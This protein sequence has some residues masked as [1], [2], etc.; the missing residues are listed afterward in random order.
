MSQWILQASSGLTARDVA[1]TYV[2]DNKV[3]MSDGYQVGNV[4]RLDI[5]NSSNGK[6]WNT[7]TYPHP[8]QKYPSTGVH[9]GFMWFI[10]GTVNKTTDG[11]NFTQVTATG[12]VPP[13]LPEAPFVS[14]NGKMHIIGNDKVYSSTDGTSWTVKSAP[15]GFRVFHMACVFDGKVFVS[16]GGYNTPNSPAEGGY[17]DKTSLND[18]WYTSTPEDETSW[19]Q[20][21]APFE[22]RF[23]PAMAVHNNALYLVGGYN[24][25][26][27]TP[28]N[29]GDTWKTTDGIN[30]SKVQ[31]SQSFPD[32]HAP[33]VY[34]WDGSLYLACGNTNTGNSIQNDVWKL[35]ETDMSDP[36]QVT[37]SRPTT[38]TANGFGG[39]TVR[40]RIP[41]SEMN[42]PANTPTFIRLTLDGASTGVGECYVG[43]AGVDHDFASTPTQ[44]TK[45]GQNSFTVAG[46][47]EVTDDIPFVWDGI[48]DII[49][50]TYIT[51]GNL[52]KVSGAGYHYEVA[53]N[54]ANTIGATGFYGSMYNPNITTIVSKI[55]M[56]G[57]GASSG[58]GTPP[59]PVL[60]GY[61]L[62]N[63]LIDSAETNI[64]VNNDTALTDLKDAMREL[65]NILDV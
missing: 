38:S 48:S 15:W 18:V 2:Y 56:D 3:W 24:N 36:I 54:K 60:T 8:F 10:D 34:S 43:H 40:T 31:V 44:V 21:Q 35:E 13:Y 23:W 57:Y 59:D 42:A 58:G 20:Y 37:F 33:S 53:G 62:V 17:T 16:C 41:A 5:L 4:P 22:P 7:V 47:N 50:S 6:N 51:S 46:L 55:E 32:R 61:A 14:L 27:G 1:V 39:Y 52:R 30:W 12:D 63:S 19:V 64:G 26:I 65:V 25:V 11:V 29:F 28:A 9:N 45:G 49:I